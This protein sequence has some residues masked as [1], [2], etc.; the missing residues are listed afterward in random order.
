M[1]NQ[2]I[3]FILPSSYTTYQGN[4]TIDEYVYDFSFHVY[5]NT[6]IPIQKLEVYKNGKKYEDVIINNIESNYFFIKDLNVINKGNHH[7]KAVVTLSDNKSYSNGFYLKIRNAYIPNDIKIIHFSTQGVHENFNALNVLLNVETTYHIYDITLYRKL[8]NRN[9]VKLGEMNK[10][11]YGYIY[12]DLIFDL[13]LTTSSIMFYK[14]IISTSNGLKKEATLAVPIKPSSFSLN[15]ISYLGNTYNNNYL[16]YGGLVGEVLSPQSVFHN[17]IFEL[18]ID[19]RNKKFVSITI[20][21]K[22]YK[23][24][25]EN[26]N[27]QYPDRFIQSQTN[28]SPNVFVITGRGLIKQILSTKYDI[29]KYDGCEFHITIYCGNDHMTTWSI[30][31]DSDYSLAVSTEKTLNNI[32]RYQNNYLNTQEDFHDETISNITYDGILQYHEGLLTFLDTAF[33]GNVIPIDQS[34]ID[35]LFKTSDFVTYTL[36]AFYFITFDNKGIHLVIFDG[37]NYDEVNYDITLYEPTLEYVKNNVCFKFETNNQLKIEFI[38]YDLTKNFEIVL[39][40]DNTLFVYNENTLIADIFNTLRSQL[41]SQLNMPFT[42]VHNN[43]E[44]TAIFSRNYLLKEQLFQPMNFDNFIQDMFMYYFSIA[45]TTTAVIDGFEYNAE[46]SIRAAVNISKAFFNIEKVDINYVIDDYASN[47]EKYNQKPI[48][49]MEELNHGYYIKCDK[50]L[51]TKNKDDYGKYTSC[52]LFYRNALIYTL[53]PQDILSNEHF[54]YFD[55]CKGRIIAINAQ[56]VFLCF[57]KN[58]QFIINHININ[59]NKHLHQYIIDSNVSCQYLWTLNEKQLMTFTNIL[60]IAKQNEFVPR[61][62]QIYSISDYDVLI[63]HTSNDISGITMESI[64][65]ISTNDVYHSFYYEYNV[66]YPL[67]IKNRNSFLQEPEIAL[68]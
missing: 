3:T 22:R 12:K 68:L 36:Y 58:K 23:F 25:A 18:L 63:L 51:K 46:L 44:M 30:I 7:F 43:Q 57:Y 53:K 10:G 55:V 59:E 17:D 16:I 19:S 32:V 47:N 15:T 1:T 54:M 41:L 24:Y 40:Q 6:T 49:I 62:M 35:N 42:Y 13:T 38:N 28:E 37:I 31:P 34:R 39:V 65:S 14:V 21:E 9:W 20:K 48:N 4:Y 33:N 64:T 2:D 52:E 26:F 50:S 56:E 8:L 5:V 27:I 11:N 61:K 66:Q 45:I 67:N 60:S 29:T